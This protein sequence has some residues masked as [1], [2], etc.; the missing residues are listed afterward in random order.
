MISEHHR[1]LDE[2]YAQAVDWGKRVDA[3]QSELEALSCQIAASKARVQGLLSSLDTSEA[4][5]RVD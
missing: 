1:Q 3:L 5:D 2:L 4:L